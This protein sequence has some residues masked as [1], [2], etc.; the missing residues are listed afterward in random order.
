MAGRLVNRQRDYEEQPW[1]RGFGLV[2]VNTEADQPGHQVIVDSADNAP[3]TD[4]WHT[5]V[6][7]L[8]KPPKVALI[9]VLETP[10]YGGD[11][12]WASSRCQPRG[13]T[14]RVAISSFSA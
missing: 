9:T 8:E 5:D 2:T 1:S 12:M 14:S 13:R 7:W 6:S 11:T 4:L 3:G 10:P